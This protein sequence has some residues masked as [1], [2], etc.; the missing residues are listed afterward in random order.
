MAS[1]AKASVS[2]RAASPSVDD[3]KSAGPP[4]NAAKKQ[5]TSIFDE[6]APPPMRHI[7][8]N[9]GMGG[10]STSLCKIQGVV[11]RTKDEVVNGPKGPIPKKRIDIVVTGVVPNGAGDVIRT[12]IEGETFLF[13]SRV[14][15][16]PEAAEAGAA[17]GE[18]KFKAKARELIVD[19]HQK[20]R[21][22]STFS[23]SFYKD[24]KDGGE[25]GVVAC[26]AGMLVEISGV[27]VNAVTKAGVTNF[28]LNG[29]KVTCLMDKAP[30][31]GE[32]ARHMINLNKQEKMQEWSAFTGSIPVKGFF[33]EDALMVM[34]PAQKH[35]AQQCQAQ[36][37]RL[38]EGAADRL[39]IMA[40]GKDAEVAS[41]LEGHESRIRAT[42]ASKV[43]G[44][45]MNLFLIDQYDCTLA[46]IVQVGLTPTNKTPEMMQK[47]QAGGEAAES[48]PP[49]FTAP[50]VVNVETNGKALSVDMRIAYIFDKDAAVGL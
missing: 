12:G 10:D 21:K 25:T 1:K 33:D 8:A 29:G 41:I 44:G 31:A 15:D 42:E 20:V 14:V 46:P 43:A 47:L 32:L 6:P 48:L 24:S 4:S 17:G 45:D 18:G 38:I 19:A 13:P 37:S 11:T 2:K 30:S 7:R 27:C 34:N 26:E 28:Y 50:W 49:M 40:Q 23:S 39:G 36:W 22:L 16:T 5:M 3:K 9:K 35:Q